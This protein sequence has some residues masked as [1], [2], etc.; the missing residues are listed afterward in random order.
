[1]TSTPSKFRIMALVT[2]LC[3]SI[4]LMMSGLLGAA[5][6]RPALAGWAAPTQSTS[7]L[8][9]ELLEQ[10]FALEADGTLHLVYRLVGDLDSSADL[11]AT[12]TT[13][14][15]TPTTAPPTTS[16]DPTVPA[17]TP[18][19]DS[20]PTATTPSVATPPTTS[21]TSPPPPPPPQ[22]TIEVTNY[23][24]IRTD[25]IIDEVVGSNV[26]STA[27]KNVVDGVA[28]GDLR[29][30]A[31][32]SSDGSATFTLDIETDVVDSVEEKLKFDQAGLYPVR[33]EIL[34]GDP[35]QDKVVATAGTIVQRLPGPDDPPLETAAA[36]IPTTNAPPIDLAVVTAIPPVEPTATADAKRSVDVELDAA[37]NLAA[38]ISS[39]VT[40]EVPPP[41]IATRAELPNGQQQLGE[42]LADDEFVAL[43]LAPLD[44]SAAAA[45][46][47]TD[48]YARLLVAGEDLLTAAVPTTP[49]RRDIW[50]ATDPLSA[51]GAQE[52]R[53]LGVRFVVMPSELF[54]DTVSPRL[55]RTDQFVD[56]EL[57]DGGTL[58]LLVVDDLAMQLTTEAADDILTK[59]TPTEWA[60]QTI[61]T[62]L[63]DQGQREQQSRPNANDDFATTQ[64][65]T[66]LSRVLT[67]PALQAPD[68]RLLTGLEQLAA[69]T[70]GVRFAA[71]SSLTGVTDVQTRGGQPV[72][73]ELPEV[74]GPSLTARIELIDSTTLRMLSAASMLA[75]V[76]PRPTE[77]ASE[78]DAL[79]ST[80]Y[81][82][83]EIEAAT[84]DLLAKADHLKHAVRLP[85]P[86]TFTLTGRSGTI[87][88]RMENDIDEPLDVLLQFSS[89]KVNFPQGDRLVTLRP[90]GETSV[91]VPVEARSNGTSSIVVDVSTPAG[92]LLDEPISLTSRVTGLTGFGQVL[93]AGFVLVLIT[94]WFTLWRST[95]RAALTDD[96]RDRH[97][98]AKQ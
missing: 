54:L 63:V 11:R 69:T 50:L 31:E 61:A 93:T 68:T 92:E 73:V 82:D 40:L 87:E 20:T 26:E 88:I 19:T 25:S 22:L 83:D 5:S 59:A 97:P 1:V 46:G 9:L 10:D 13:S 85:E 75:D 3:C 47:R 43:P 33:V 14:S 42:D 28:L 24:P 86:F 66:K 52:L 91:V 37:I 94:W 95:R 4:M 21:T 76:D 6:G 65:S 38:T 96:G 57:P 2:T 18:P 41:L 44:V 89:P 7:G 81:S 51:A 35:G 23:A 78:L 60:V 70:P 64:R 58:A 12:T 90:N 36:D 77:W 49:S 56:I 74:A 16:P 34:I 79:I 84:D 32:F 48:A 15:T 45:V 55:P 27:F 80:G 8:R 72:T 98:S 29:D 30:R 39:P 67:T 71:G 62:M 53:D 17:E